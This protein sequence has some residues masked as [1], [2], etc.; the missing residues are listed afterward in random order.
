M[1]TLAGV[2]LI[3]TLALALPAVGQEPQAP[4]GERIIEAMLIWRLVDELDLNEG[5]IARIF[6]RIKALKEIRLEMGRRAP[7]LTREIRQLIA[8]AP[9]DDDAIRIK[10]T[11]L[12]MMRFQMEA[13]RRRQLQL[14]ASVL[15]VEQMGKFTLIQESFETETLRLLQEMRRIVEDQLPPRR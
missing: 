3:T 15:T 13:R 12:N 11:E 14:I 1:R 5:Q 10:V 4:R 9:R 6:P 8:Q 2:V 7:P